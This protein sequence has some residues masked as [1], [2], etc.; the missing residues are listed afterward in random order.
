MK[1]CVV[2]GSGRSGTSMVAGTLSAAG[3]YLGP[4]LL[5]A[6]VS[7]PKGYFESRTVNEINELLLE[8]RVRNGWSTILP[9]RV[10]QWLPSGLRPFDLGQRWLAP[11]GEH[12]ERP[13]E[14]AGEVIERMQACVDVE[15]FC[16][17][18]PRFSYTL[19]DW[20][21]LRE[22]HPVVVVVFRHPAVSVES[23]V[24]DS[25]NTDYLKRLRVDRQIALRSWMSNYEAVLA[26]GASTDWLFLHY[27]QLLYGNGVDRLAGELAAP[28]T[29]EFLDAA[30]RR[31]SPARAVP[32]RA[33]ALY[34]ELCRRAEFT[35]PDLDKSG[36]EDMSLSASRDPR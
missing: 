6:T 18:D 16:L 36:L 34:Q 22:K 26:N 33:L 15:P 17:K 32:H 10:T 11:I 20:P 25:R 3:Y 28:V 27:D 21:P 12:G 30:L 14:P 31:S 24:K 1:N 13:Q 29:R 19:D 9:R 4:N 5:P 7:N 35:D 23:I 8:D 2:L